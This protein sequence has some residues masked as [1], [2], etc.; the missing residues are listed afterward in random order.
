MRKTILVSLFLFFILLMMLSCSV[1]KKA[2]GDGRAGASSDYYYLAEQMPEVFI[3]GDSLRHLRLPPIVLGASEGDTFFVAYY[4]KS[5]GIPMQALTKDVWRSAR[6]RDGLYANDYGTPGWTF[7]SA[8]LDLSGANMLPSVI[9]KQRVTSSI[10]TRMQK[11]GIATDVTGEAITLSFVEYT[12]YEE[13]HV[14]LTD[15]EARKELREKTIRF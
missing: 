5:I 11:A 14:F 6:W 12:F 13:H 9:H 1:E 7:A 3:Y 8:L 15:D 2:A 10:M 4:G